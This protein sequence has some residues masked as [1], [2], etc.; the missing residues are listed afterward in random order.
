MRSGFAGARGWRS[1]SPFLL[2]KAGYAYLM[3]LLRAC[4]HVFEIG[5]VP[6][7]NNMRGVSIKMTADSAV[8][9]FY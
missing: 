4:F 8:C 9:I 2:R 6:S 5:S 1:V 3:S 7:I